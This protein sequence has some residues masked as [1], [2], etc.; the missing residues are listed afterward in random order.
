[1][2]TLIRSVAQKYGDG[3]LNKL[4]ITDAKGK[5]IIVDFIYSADRMLKGI[6]FHGKK[7]VLPSGEDIVGIYVKAEDL[8]PTETILNI[9]PITLDVTVDA[10][11]L[12][13]QSL[14]VKQRDGYSYDVLDLVCLCSNAP[15]TA[16]ALATNLLLGGVVQEGLMISLS[17][18][19]TS[20]FYQLDTRQNRYRW[21]RL[22][23]FQNVLTAYMDANA[24][25]ATRFRWNGV[26]AE[27]VLL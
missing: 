27:Y 10:N 18:G 5:V 17:V 2:S 8:R 12:T 22:K 9:I 3:R 23:E 6:N 21:H 26:V 15:A 19:F 13:N 24:T 25:A 7:G 14:F 20:N 16:P 4:S 1:M 11:T